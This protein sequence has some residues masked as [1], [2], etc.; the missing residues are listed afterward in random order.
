MLPLIVV[1]NDG[2]I[3]FPGLPVLQWR[4]D[5]FKKA[6][7]A[8]ID[9]LPEGAPDGNQ[10]PPQR[11]VIGNARVA[12]SS[13][14]NSVEGPQLPQ[15]VVRHHFSGLRVRFAAPVKR[16]PMQAKIDTRPRRFEHANT[17][18]TNFLSDAISGDD[19]NV[20]SFH[21]F[22][23]TNTLILRQRAP[24]RR[25]TCPRA[26]GPFLFF[27]FACRRGKSWRRAA[28]RELARRR[29]YQRAQAAALFRGCWKASEFS[30][31]RVASGFSLKNRSRARPRL[32]PS[33]RLLPPRPSHH[34]ASRSRAGCS[35]NRCRALPAAGT[36]KLRTER[37]PIPATKTPV[38]RGNRRAKEEA[39]P[40]R[41]LVN[42]R[43]TTAPL[44]DAKFR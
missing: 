5:S 42:A 28:G 37:G 4:F 3:D 23:F 35:A 40:R 38:A 32:I 12:N 41:G 21:Q 7:R 31:R 24:M 39:T 44:F 22:L 1:A 20:E 19:R 9:V 10:K 2:E 16:V 17:L 18:G 14:E 13:E 11:D 33:T 43:A 34:L 36:T 26:D 15:A 29:V 8:K 30:W 25:F 6:H 27:W